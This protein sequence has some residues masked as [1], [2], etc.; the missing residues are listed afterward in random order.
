MINNY[1]FYYL[2][3][4]YNFFLFSSLILFFFST[5]LF[6]S[7][8][9]E[10]KNIEISKPFEIN[11]N[12]NDVIDEGFRKSFSELLS[13]IVNSKD[14]KKITKIKLNEI[15]G[16]VESFT[17]KEEKFIDEIY[18]MNLGVTFNRKKIYNY[19][20]QN[21][22]FPSIPLKK[23]FLFIPI[24]INEENQELLIFSDNRIY[25]EWNN[26]SQSYDLIKYVMP[27]EDL[28]DI[29]IIK[30]NYEFIE[31]Y[32]F[33]E[34]I[35]KY[36][37]DRSIIL[38]I[39]KNDKDVRV[40]SRITIKDK[41]SLKNETFSNI[42]LESENQFEL[43]V[44]QLRTT[45]ED[46]WKDY[47][48]INTSIKLPLIIELENKDNLKISKF[49]KVLSEKDLISNYRILKFNKDSVYYKIIYNGTPNSFL[50]VMSE[51][52]Y[53]FNTDNKVWKLK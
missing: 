14:K 16:M 48:Q 45:Y 44:N 10:I 21:N 12:K 17:I 32:N 51:N 18:H 53:S 5:D 30:K 27:T 26:Y 24:I 40:L 25:N 37:L 19:L 46:Y 9:F 52:N 28:E 13:L 22:I 34:I 41:V 39:F 35:N 42:D 20:N 38:L 2:E 8:A 3:K 29:N 6:Q 4:L 15:K 49:E 47:N 7:K 36:V 11:F 33:N 1:K 50:K 43:L 23:N 31:E